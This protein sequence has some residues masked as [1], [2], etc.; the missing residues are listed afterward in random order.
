M[1]ACTASPAMSV[2]LAPKRSASSPPPMRPAIEARPETPSTVAA[3][4]AATPWSVACVTMWKIGPEWAAQHARRVESPTS[5]ATRGAEAEAKGP[6]R[7]RLAGEHE[8]EPE[9]KA[10]AERDAAPADAVGERAPAERAESH[11]GPVEQR[12][13]RDRAAA[14][15][16]RALDRHEEHAEREQRAEADADDRRGCGDDDPAVEDAAHGWRL[17]QHARHVVQA[18]LARPR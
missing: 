2:G 6:Q 12:D 1:A 3:A 11:R 7:L 13:R 16:H 8:A 14:P 17:R 9:Q 10:A 15:A 4:I 5:E 18:L